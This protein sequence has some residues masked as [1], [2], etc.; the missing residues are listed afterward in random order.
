MHRKLWDYERKTHGGPVFG[1]GNNHW[2]WSGCLD[3]VEAQF[4]SGWPGEAGR[5]AP[6]LVDFDLLKIHP[7]ELNHGMGY[8][9]RWWS[10]PTWGGI[11]PLVILD[12]YRMQEV[13]FGHAGF[14][15][16]STWSL[17]PLAWL[18]HHLLTP[19]MARFT[20]ARPVAIQYD[21]NGKWV[22]ATAAAQSEGNS[23]AWQRVR[24]R[25]DNGLV[26]T[27]NQAEKALHVGNRI[28]G[29]YGWVA[30]GAGVTAWTAVRDG[31]VADY[32]ETANSVF[33]NARSAGDWNL[34]GSMR[35]HPEV[36]SF[37][38]IGPRRC[39]VTYGWQVKQTLPRNYYCF[40]HFNKKGAGESDILFQQD[41]RLA[42][43]TSRWRSGS[44][45]KD[46]P[47]EILVPDSLPDGDYSWTIGLFTPVDGRLALEGVEDGAGRIRLGT[48]RVSEGGR[49]LTLLREPE[50]GDRRNAALCGASESARQG[51]RLWSR[52][53]RRQRAAGA[54]WISVDRATFPRDRAF[55]LLLDAS[56][57]GQPT[58]IRCEGGRAR[59]AAPIAE[60]AFW[61]LPLNGASQYQWSVR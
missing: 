58:E 30:E 14:L 22:D 37:E 61:K 38:V 59:T 25:Y 57:F 4:G 32:A 40:V 21:L 17:I 41:H 11:P 16:A 10:K 6:L 13:A 36:D 7:L 19:V 47:H 50:A 51:H 28:L 39:R 27:A 60:G 24:V 53:D 8:Y 52:A 35:I 20:T 26:I 46:G 9:E 1:E 12:Q 49:K 54:R 18:E 31:V 56:R 23:K 2:Y 15:G 29:Q 34:G 45:V 5:E 33:A 55:T 48:L 42:A 3:G 44:T 43:P